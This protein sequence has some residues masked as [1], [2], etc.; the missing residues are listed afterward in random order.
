MGGRSSAT[1][2]LLNILRFADRPNS[3]FRHVCRVETWPAGLAR[4]LVARLQLL[5]RKLALSSRGDSSMHKT[6]I[7]LSSGAPKEKPPP[8][9]DAKLTAQVKRNPIQRRPVNATELAS[10]LEQYDS[11]IYK[12]EIA[13]AA[14]TTAARNLTPIATSYPGNGPVADV[15]TS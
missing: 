1:H 8:E 12:K 10:L 13:D 4:V 11:E 6:L 15:D 3:I 7:D 5:I 14:A 9:L 2:K